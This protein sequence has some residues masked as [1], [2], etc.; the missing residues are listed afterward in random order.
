MRNKLFA[1][2]V[3]A[4]ALCSPAFADQFRTISNVTGKLT[5]TRQPAETVVNLSAGATT[6]NVALGTVFVTGINTG[7]TAITGFSNAITG[8]VITIVGKSTTTSNATTIADSAPFRLSAAFTASANNVIRI[9][10]RGAS[11]YVEIGRSSN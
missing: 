5:L 10:V 9:L 7:A 1:A 2:L 6:P 4:L 3:A 11:D 8:N